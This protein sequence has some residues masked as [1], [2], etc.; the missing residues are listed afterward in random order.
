[1]YCA[2][3]CGTP[4]LESALHD[5]QLCVVAVGHVPAAPVLCCCVV[6]EGSV[7]EGDVR[8]TVLKLKLCAHTYT[9]THC[10]DRALRLLVSPMFAL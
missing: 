2:V 9:H 8:A 3:L 4:Y 5:L 7:G 6:C 1:M 10:F